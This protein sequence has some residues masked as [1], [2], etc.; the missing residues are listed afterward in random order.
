[1]PVSSSALPASPPQPPWR[2]RRRMSAN[3]RFVLREG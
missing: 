1:M 3:V 2:I